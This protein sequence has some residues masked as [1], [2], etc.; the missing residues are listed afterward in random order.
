MLED[1]SLTAQYV[2]EQF[3]NVLDDF[4]LPKDPD[5]H[6]V[7]DGGS[8][9]VGALGLCSFYNRDDCFCHLIS[10]GI[11][12]VLHKT[13]SKKV[14]GAFYRYYNEAKEIF[15]MIDSSHSLAEY[16][17]RAGLN[18]RLKHS[19]KQSNDTRWNSL[20]MMLE[21]ILLEYEAILL[22]CAEKGKQGMLTSIDKVLLETTVGLLKPFADVTKILE[23]TNTPSIQYVIYCRNELLK[24]LKSCPS[25]RKSVKNIKKRLLEE[26]ASRMIIKPLYVA[27][28]FLDPV[29]CRSMLEDGLSEVQIE[30]GKELIVQLAKRKPLPQHPPEV[31]TPASC[32]SAANCQ[33]KIRL[34]NL[35]IKKPKAS[36]Q[37]SIETKLR[38]EFSAYMEMEMPEIEEIEDWD[39]LRF[40][41][42][43]ARMFPHLSF[44]ARIILAIPPNSA[45]S[46]S[47]FSEAGQIKTAKR[48]NLNPERLD[49]LMLLRENW[50]LVQGSNN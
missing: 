1:C 28:A 15:D 16:S 39:V 20:L 19:I 18:L 32:Q 27:A 41:K 9:M 44:V 42:D 34:S 8:N 43:N 13:T 5:Y 21:S 24:H 26:I 45:K 47:D 12:Y 4:K 38:R 36:S 6:V 48:S 10:S 50:D 46:E 33:K 25:D 37:I 3:N 29:T 49:Q 35:L 7:T 40:W 11:K 17:K 30:E 22:L 14:S 23:S 2:K 31:A